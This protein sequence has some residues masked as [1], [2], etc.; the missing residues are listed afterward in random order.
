[1]KKDDTQ[2]QDSAISSTRRK[3]LQTMSLGVAGAGALSLPALGN[4]RI[5]RLAEA[6]GG[7]A[8]PFK[9]ALIEGETTL[10]DGH[11]HAY[12][13]MVH[14]DGTIEGTTDVVNGHSH[15]IQ[16]TIDE[17]KTSISEDGA[18]FHTLEPQVSVDATEK[19]WGDTIEIVGG[20]FPPSLTAVSVKDEHGR[21]YELPTVSVSPTAVTAVAVPL[22]GQLLKEE[23]LT[24][25]GL[26]RLEV[27]SASQGISEA[28]DL[29]FNPPKP[30]GG[31]DEVLQDVLSA[32]DE[33]RVAFQGLRQAVQ[34]R[35]FTTGEKLDGK[36]QQRFDELMVAMD[37][38]DKE[39]EEIN[40]IVAN[41]DNL[42]EGTLEAL[43]MAAKG[44]RDTAVQV[45]ALAQAIPDSDFIKAIETIILCIVE[46]VGIATV[47]V[48][49]LK[50]MVAVCAAVIAIP[51]IGALL[52]ALTVM[53]ASF[54]HATAVV[55][56][57]IR[58]IR[59]IEKIVNC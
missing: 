26:A 13:I 48:V 20:P 56:K 55:V 45:A 30:A 32:A 59:H 3:F 57:I 54:V 22:R 4:D 36:A 29:N 6:L 14:P 11:R 24:N 2:K 34:D 44:T 38:L 17:L 8:A 28:I 52:C 1:M 58:V 23:A 43:T 10:A 53:V 19:T 51:F 47:Q 25:P 33:E 39:F 50:V 31:S 9:E 12:S 16:T 7:R 27:I 37:Q 5:D 35:L 18:H 21:A 15:T 41:I 46:L 40:A 42:P 49:V